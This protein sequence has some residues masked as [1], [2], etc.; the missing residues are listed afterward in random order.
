[1]RWFADETSVKVAGV[2]RYVYRAVDEHGQVIDVLV[3]ARRDI[4]AA[5][6]FFV[7]MLAVHED[8]E[9]ITTD[10]APAL[11]AVIAEL[12]PAAVHD[13]EQYANNRMECD[14]GRLKARLRPMRGLKSFR[15][16]RTI[17]AGH[18]FIQNLRRGHYEL[19][20][21]A[22]H[23]RLRVAAAFGELARAI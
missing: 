6:R 3:S 7:R 13:T 22:R 10:R 15:S 2:W 14:H 16:A 12:L 23:S 19:G 17:I 18:A 4:A 8:P 21:E 1:M 20:L 9:E 5:R 11:A